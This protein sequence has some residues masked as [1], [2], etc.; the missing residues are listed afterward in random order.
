MKKETLQELISLLE[1]TLQ[2]LKN[3]QIT[4]DYVHR[5]ELENKRLRKAIEKERQRNEE[6]EKALAAPPY[7]DCREVYDDGEGYPPNVLCKKWDIWID[8]FE[9]VCERCQG[10]FSKE[11]IV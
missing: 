2:N 5:I 3:K 6:L 11:Q 4:Q 8:E 9:S 7:P 10:K 1:E